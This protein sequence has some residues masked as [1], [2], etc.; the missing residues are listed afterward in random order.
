M[1]QNFKTSYNKT[2]LQKTL[3]YGPTDMGFLGLVPILGSKKILI[4]D[5]LADFIYLS[6][7]LS[8]Y[9]R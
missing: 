9:L 1:R 6:I 8:I 5:L 2:E 4:S 3:E 7:Y